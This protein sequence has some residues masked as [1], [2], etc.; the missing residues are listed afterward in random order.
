MT[1]GELGNKFRDCPQENWSGGRFQRNPPKRCLKFPYLTRESPLSPHSFA[2]GKGLIKFLFLKVKKHN[3]IWSFYF[4]Y[5]I[6]KAFLFSL[7]KVKFF[8]ENQFPKMTR[9]TFAF[10]DFNF[11]KLLKKKSWISNFN[12]IY[13]NLEAFS[14]I[15]WKNCWKYLQFMIMKILSFL[16]TKTWMSNSYLKERTEPDMSSMEDDLSL[17]LCLQ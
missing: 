9:K 13:F 17:K 16:K 2:I 8:K 4:Q 5:L 3:N 12:E 15:L 6:F 1:L 14:T 11:L 7:I 10:K